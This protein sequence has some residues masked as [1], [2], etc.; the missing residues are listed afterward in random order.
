MH[1]VQHLR[2]AINN[3]L[4]FYAKGLRKFFV[5]N[6]SFV[7]VI[8]VVATALSCGVACIESLFVHGDLRAFPL[9]KGLFPHQ[10]NYYSYGHYWRVFESCFLFC[11]FFYCNAVSRNDMLNTEDAVKRK[12]FL[13]SIKKKDFSSFLKYLSF[14]LLIHLVIYEPWW[15]NLYGYNTSDDRYLF[16]GRSDYLTGLI[17]YVVIFVPITLVLMALKKAN[18]VAKEKVRT[19]VTEVFAV[20]LLYLVFANLYVVLSNF[21]DSYIATLIYNVFGDEPFV[22]IFYLVVMIAMMS[23]FVTGFAVSLATVAGIYKP[24]ETV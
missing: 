12:T 7:L 4:D 6:F 17:Y 23:L 22:Y 16:L 2:S 21:F 24:N 9:D 13:S 1:I 18:R 19:R 5:M 15:S 14:L 10:G 3:S 20:F 11:G 8:G